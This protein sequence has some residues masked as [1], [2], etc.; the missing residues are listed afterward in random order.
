MKTYVKLY[1]SSEGAGPL[2][3]VEDL[4]NMGF[5][6]EVGEYDFSISWESPEQYVSIMRS[7]H[8]ALAG[9]RVRYTVMSSS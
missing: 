7:L 3:I 6:T 4:R 9:T 5:R 1:F 2:D 8:N